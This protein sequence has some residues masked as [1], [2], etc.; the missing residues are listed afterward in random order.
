MPLADAP[1]RPG[2]RILLDADGT[3]V[4]RFD[5]VER[6]GRRTAELLELEA[7]VSTDQ[8]VDVIRGDLAGWRV[9]AHVPVGEAL[10]AAGARP[11]RDAHVMSRDL[12]RDPP[13]PGWLEPAVPDGLRLTPAERP[14]SDLAAAYAAAFPSD[15]PDF[16]HMTRPDRPE[17]ELAE[18][19]SGRAMGP[20]MRASGLAVDAEGAVVGAIVVCANSGEPPLGGPWIAQVF[21]HPEARGAGGALLR[22]ALAIAARDGLPAL[23]LAVTHGNPAIAVYENHGFA[24]V[25]RSISVELPKA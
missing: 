23:G 16:A 25:L 14:A 2:G 10:I 13:E 1:D 9:V 18:L 4:A 20:V 24:D 11:R 15:H 22:R 6:D 3:P 5:L 7:G 19:L 12:V 8:A 17:D 21:R